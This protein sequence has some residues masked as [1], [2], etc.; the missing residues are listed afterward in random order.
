MKRLVVLLLAAGFLG[1][2]FGAVSCAVDREDTETDYYNRALAAWVRIHCDPVPAADDSGVFFLEYT[3]GGGE[4]IPD[5]GY[6]FVSYVR[7]S[8][9]G[10]IASTNDEQLNR[11]L[12]TWTRTGYYGSRIWQ[13]GYNFLPIALE[14]AFRRMNVGDRAVIAVPAPQTRVVN[15]LYST[16][17]SVESANVIY[18]VAIDSVKRDIMAWQDERLA[19]RSRTLYGGVDTL[20]DGLYFV[21]VGAPS[22]DSIPN[23]RTLN[24]RY[25]GRRFDGTVFDTNIRDTARAHRIFSES[26][27][28]SALNITYH[29]DFDEMKQNNTSY[30]SGFLRGIH[31]TKIGDTSIVFFR[32]DHGYGQRGNTSSIP[33]Y[34]P[35]EFTV[36][37]E[38]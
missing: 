33:E 23:E 38:K 27:A 28:Y 6:V 1:L 2:A 7:K 16:F 15:T 29:R 4:R 37:I 17:P 20:V 32:S 21:P 25:I 14:N 22:G 26:N 24:I 12:G 35:L 10:N 13:A 8:L 3:P 31:E 30:I 5:T 36:I 34:C 19:D 9:Q 11:Q 18:E